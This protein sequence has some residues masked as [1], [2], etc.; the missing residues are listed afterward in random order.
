[1]R[2][3][4]WFFVLSF[5]SPVSAS[6]FDKDGLVTFTDY[7]LFVQ[8]YGSATGD[9][10]YAPEFDLDSNGKIDLNDFSLFA[11]TFGNE[12]HADKRALKA[13]E[14]EELAKILSENGKSELAI[15]KYK[16][17]LAIAPNELQKARTLMHLGSLHLKIEN[18]PKAEEYLKQGVNDFKESKNASVQYHLM[19][20]V[21][22]L[23]EVERIQGN[24]GLASLYLAQTK[25]F[26]P[27]PPQ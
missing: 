12:V 6:D 26:L 25:M 13:D 17:V 22:I 5:V 3:L 16:E 27:E 20:C 10:L 18:L 15:E 14:L 24:H 1:M 23:S 19:W 21:F 2:R 9:E 8:R 4:L 11:E 7:I